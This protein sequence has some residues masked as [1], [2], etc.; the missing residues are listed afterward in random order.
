[1]RKARRHAATHVAVEDIQ[2]IQ[3][4]LKHFLE[5]GGPTA[6]QR[7]RV[8]QTIRQL[9][10]LQVGFQDRGA[11]IPDRLVRHVLW[12]LAQIPG[13]LNRRRSMLD[14]ILDRR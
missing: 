2:A 11:V 13:F 1:M 4:L 10:G 12:A 7:R 14:E 5:L 6:K 9:H 3:R 8:R